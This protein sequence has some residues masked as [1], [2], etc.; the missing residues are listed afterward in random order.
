M[1]FSGVHDENTNSQKTIFSEGGSNEDKKEFLGRWSG[2][3]EY[4]DPVTGRS[5]CDTHV[6]NGIF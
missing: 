6:W 4:D 2:L 1:T 3:R 5:L